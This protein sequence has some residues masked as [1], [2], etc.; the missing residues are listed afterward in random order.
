MEQPGISMTQEKFSSPEEELA[1]LREQVAV[2]ERELLARGAEVRHEAVVSDQIRDYQVAP[3]GHVLHEDY[4][5]KPASIQSLALDLA[6]ETH[7]G[8][9]NEILAIMS[10]KGIKNALAVVDALNDPHVEDDF[11]RFLVQYIKKGYDI[12]QRAFHDRV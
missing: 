9:I 6:P 12:L 11:H 3:A 10:E 5:L 1:H 2:R 8:R 7:D 4:R